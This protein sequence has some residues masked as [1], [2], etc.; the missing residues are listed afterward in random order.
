MSRHTQPVGY[1][2]T[3]ALGFTTQL[4]VASIG[5]GYDWWQWLLVR[6]VH[7]SGLLIM[8]KIAD[9]WSAVFL[10]QCRGGF[11]CHA[12]A[13]VTV[14]GGNGGKCGFCLLGIMVYFG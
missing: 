4:V 7:G 3:G 2:G 1:D 10:Q 6:V 5:D 8:I 14:G 13:M 12:I 11:G 9:G